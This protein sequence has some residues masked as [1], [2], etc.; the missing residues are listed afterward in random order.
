VTSGDSHDSDQPR[1]AAVHAGN[2]TDAVYA[3]ETPV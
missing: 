3:Y 1:T 2:G